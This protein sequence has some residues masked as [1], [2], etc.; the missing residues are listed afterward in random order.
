MQAYV[1]PMGEPANRV[2]SRAAPHRS[3]AAPAPSRPVPA[4]H[5]AAAAGGA[6]PVRPGRTLVTASLIFATVEAVVS[7]AV[8]MTPVCRSHSW[9]CELGGRGRAAVERDGE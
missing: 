1:L 2:A 7:R 3:G 4:P 5:A 9:I 6:A 8:E